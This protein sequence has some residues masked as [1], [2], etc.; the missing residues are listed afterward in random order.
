MVSVVGGSGDW[1]NEIFKQT[2]ERR[3]TMLDQNNV[4]VVNYAVLTALIDAI[5]IGAALTVILLE[6]PCWSILFLVFGLGFSAAWI[7]IVWSKFSK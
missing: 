4:V 2:D 1:E 7:K 5:C 6:H 3:V